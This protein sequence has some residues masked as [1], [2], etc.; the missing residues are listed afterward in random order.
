MMEQPIITV[1]SA[2]AA[3][4]RARVRGPLLPGLVALHAA[5]LAQPHGIETRTA[6]QSLLISLQDGDPPQSISASGLYWDME[7]RTVAPGILPY[8]V[9]AQL[10][11]DGAYK[12]RF[13]ALPGNAQIGFSANDAWEFPLNTVLVKN[14]YLEFE[15]GN[16][17]SREIIETRFLVLGEKGRWGG[18]SYKWDNRS[19]D[20]VLLEKEEEQAYFVLDPEAEEGV[21]E[22]LHF[23]PNREQCDQCNVRASGAVL[24]VNTPQ[25]NSDH[26]YG[27]VLDNQLRTLNHIGLFTEDISSQ[28]DELPRMAD[29]FDESEPLELRA[30]SYLA[31]N[32]SH[33]HQPGIVDKA[34][35]DLRFDTALEQ[36]RTVNR[37]PTLASFDLE[38]PRI[39]K[40]GDGTNSTVYNRMLATDSN[41]M[42]PVASGVIHWRGADVIRRWID[43]LEV[44]THV[45]QTQD[46]PA[47]MVLA[48]SFPNPFNASTRIRYR[49]AVDGP[50]SITVFDAMGQA[51]RTLADRFHTAGEYAL[52]WDG[53]D[54][55]G[56][57][58]ASG[59][60]PY[61]LQAG[62]RR[63]ER[64][65]AF[66]K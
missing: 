28:L 35:F 42:P 5:A 55:T 62:A 47:D 38:D 57:V 20:A 19:E 15:A 9:S 10:W 31:A 41:R 56:R 46:L 40:P 13:I 44:S 29:P 30:R 58:V 21:R 17:D 65:L 11:S 2:V 8:S 7:S 54:E 52:Q 27:G 39:I 61:R 16:A 12:E 14:F 23:F 4:L 33:C 34:D 64:R 36:T 26:S 50:A 6:N 32:C 59:V 37:V 48:Q 49:I 45:E 43:R 3:N 51:V 1:I 18:F 53:R 22:H 24:G 66:I 25:L 60:Y 63:I